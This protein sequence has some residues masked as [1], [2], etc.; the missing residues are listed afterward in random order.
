MD[1]IDLSTKRLTYDVI[2]SPEET[3]KSDINSIWTPD[4]QQLI[5]CK[6]GDEVWLLNLKDGTERMLFASPGIFG[7]GSLVVGR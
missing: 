7:S 2:K 5:Y 6:G 3:T 4:G 1:V